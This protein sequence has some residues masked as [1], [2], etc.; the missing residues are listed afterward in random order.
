MT[1]TKKEI[2]DT[3]ALGQLLDQLALQVQQAEAQGTA[4]QFMGVHTRGIPLAKRL[5][6]RLGRDSKDLGTLDINLYRDD[7]SQ[8]YAMP[9]VKE[10]KVPFKLEGARVLLV[11]DVLY[12]GRTIRSALDA[13]SDLGRPQQIQLLVLVDRGGRELPIQ[14][15]FCGEKI[16]VA[17]GGNVKVRLSEVDGKD[18]I[19][20]MS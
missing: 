12:T 11:D 2:R 17:A 3:A 8:A 5:M 4:F 10:T 6:E 9:V 20:L 13:L 19:E 15:D 7:L 18:S 14:A 1:S 16:K